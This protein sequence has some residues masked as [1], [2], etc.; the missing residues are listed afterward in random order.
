M[1]D[2]ELAKPSSI[3]NHEVCGF[4]KVIDSYP[5]DLSPPPHI[6]YF[7]LPYSVLMQVLLVKI[8]K[9]QFRVNG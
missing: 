9:T 8:L 6:F 3:K 4:L 1:R 7:T 2:L 5:N